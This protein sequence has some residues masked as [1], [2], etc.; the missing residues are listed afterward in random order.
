MGWSILFP[1][2]GST[3]REV[4]DT[5]LAIRGG[6]DAAASGVFELVVVVKLMFIASIFPGSVAY[7]VLFSIASSSLPLRFQLSQSRESD[8]RSPSTWEF[9]LRSLF[10][11]DNTD[12][13]ASSLSPVSSGCDLHSSM[14]HTGIHT[15]E[16]MRWSRPLG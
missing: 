9:S 4:A 6:G 11:I 7:M 14:M 15:V 13:C 16:S 2:L 5:V 1:K 10:S 12:T 8:N 3:S